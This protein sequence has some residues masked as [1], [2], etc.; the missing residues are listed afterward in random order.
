MSQSGSTAFQRH[1]N[2]KRWA[3]HYENINVADAEQNRAAS[4]KMLKTGGL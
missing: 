4:E 2:K 1:E 3:T